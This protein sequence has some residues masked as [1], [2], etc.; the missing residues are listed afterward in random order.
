MIIKEADAIFFKYDANRSGFLDIREI[1]P[2]IC[3]IFKIAKINPPTYQD[4]LVL[5]KNFD[6]DGN[7]LIDQKEFRDLL[8]IMCGVDPQ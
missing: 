2:A 6:Q 7:G 4:A 8:L 5:M 3:H 1:Y